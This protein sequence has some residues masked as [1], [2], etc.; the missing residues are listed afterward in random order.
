MRY[1]EIN[2][3][4]RFIF[5]RKI[6]RAF[7]SISSIKRLCEM[8][9]NTQREIREAY[10]LHLDFA[11]PTYTFIHIHPEKIKEPAIAME[12]KLHTSFDVRESLA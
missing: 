4:G 7:I 1:D 12:I 10:Y 5:S 2:D 9:S 11:K 6:A 8:L 3:E